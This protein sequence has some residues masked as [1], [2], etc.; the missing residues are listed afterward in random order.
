[1]QCSKRPLKFVYTIKRSTFHIFRL[2]VPASCPRMYK[3][4]ILF[5]DTGRIKTMPR[6]TDIE[7]YEHKEHHIIGIKAKVS[8]DGIHE[9]IN[10]SYPRLF[11]YLEKLGEVPTDPPFLTY[12]N[13]DMSNLDITVAIPVSKELPSSNGIFP[14]K[15]PTI[16]MVRC[17]HRGSYKSI[18]ETYKEINAWISMKGYTSIGIVR[19]CYLNDP[20][21][22]P[23]DEL[24]TKITIPVV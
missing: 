21:E 10:E 7:I 20:S 13:T 24:L 8:A 17:V 16:K 15:I 1:M 12:H 9:L 11:S 3:Y 4:S 19:E 6:V 22:F 14:L 23:E 2:N 18:E 5:I